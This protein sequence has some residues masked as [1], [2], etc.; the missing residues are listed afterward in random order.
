MYFIVFIARNVFYKVLIN[1]YILEYNK[2]IKLGGVLIKPKVIKVSYIIKNTQKVIKAQHIKITILWRICIEY[3][4][5]LQRKAQNIK[6]LQPYGLLAADIE[7]D[8][9]GVG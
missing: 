5:N 1:T 9:D 8:G 4:K 7:A 6:N 3:K 2:Q